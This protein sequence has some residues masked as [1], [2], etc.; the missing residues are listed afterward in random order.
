VSTAIAGARH[1][2]AASATAPALELRDVDAGYGKV[3]VLRGVDLVVRP[4]EVVALLGPNGAGKTTLLRTAAGLLR[5]SGGSIAV[6]GSDVTRREPHARARAG[7]CLIPEG[8]G[9]FRNLTVDENLR[10][11]SPPWVRSVDYDAA[12]TAFPILKDRRTQVAGTL[13]GGQQQMLAL[14]RAILAGSSVVLVDEV[15]MG[16]AP[17]VVDVIFEALHVLVERGVAL[18]VVEQYVERALAM[19]D[20]VYLIKKGQVR[21]AGAP[22][23]LSGSALMAE[24]MGTAEPAAAT[25]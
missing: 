25:D 14:A 13:S 1:E 12:Y 17:I 9:I 3:S 2:P 23:E 5:P 4:G 8:R 10:L 7:L 16:L 18:L 15:S 6:A 22:S 11:S 20:S 24:Y 21:H 19:A